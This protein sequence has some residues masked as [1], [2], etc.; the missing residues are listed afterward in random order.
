MLRGSINHLL[1]QLR[2]GDPGF[3]CKNQARGLVFA[4]A[5]ARG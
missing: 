4:G 1:A 3:E 5:G 2:D